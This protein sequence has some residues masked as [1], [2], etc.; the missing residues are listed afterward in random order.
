MKSARH[1]QKQQKEKKQNSDYRSEYFP[2]VIKY[3]K[4]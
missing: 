2:S 3:D 4:K 1:G